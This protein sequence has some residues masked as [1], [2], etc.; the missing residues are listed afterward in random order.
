MDEKNI[1]FCFIDYTKAFDYMDHNKLW[2]ILK[3]KGISTLHVSWETCMQVKQQ[4]L[5][6]DMGQWTTNNR[7][8]NMAQNW[9]RNMSGLY[10]I[11]LLIY[12][13]CKVHHEKCQ[14]GW[15]TNW[16]KDCWEKYQQ[17]QICRWYHL[18]GRKQRV[19]K[20]PLDESEKRKW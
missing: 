13:I 8:W 3:E 7:H 11:I 12:L 6:L 10:I 19:T 17:P 14:A 5:E 2:K 16:N 18:N 4:Q 20:E 1:Y 15:I 9:E